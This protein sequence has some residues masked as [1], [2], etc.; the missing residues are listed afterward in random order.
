[1]LIQVDGCVFD[2]KQFKFSYG[3]D[4]LDP[5]GK[6]AFVNHVHLDGENRRNES[7]RIIQDW[8]SEMKGKWQGRVFRIYRDVRPDEVIIRFHLVRQFVSNWADSGVEII[9]V[10]T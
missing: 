2:E 7:D 9:E 5:V 1:M 8:M 4:S 3:F 6:E 10:I